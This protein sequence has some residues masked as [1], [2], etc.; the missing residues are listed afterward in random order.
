MKVEI[1]IFQ[2]EVREEISTIKIPVNDYFSRFNSRRLF[3]K[4]TLLSSSLIE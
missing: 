4:V 1:E 3:V 2:I